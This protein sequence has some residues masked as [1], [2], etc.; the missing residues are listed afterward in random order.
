[1]APT[2]PGQAP[3][4]PPE[5][6]ARRVR[7]AIGAWFIKSP[8][9]GYLLAACRIEVDPEL[10]APAATDGYNLLVV[11]P[12]YLEPFI[13]RGS[14]ALS[15][16]LA[17]E[18]LHIAL[19]HA[20][21][22]GSRDPRLWNVAADVV[23]NHIVGEADP[24]AMAAAEAAVN[25]LG[26]EM[27][28]A[29]RVAQALV[30]QNPLYRGR[31]PRDVEEELTRSSAE[32]I[33]GAL[34]NAAA[35]SLPKSISVPQLL[36]R[37]EGGGGA[38]GRRG[39]PGRTPP[40]GEGVEDAARSVAGR[41]TQGGR[42]EPG[43]EGDLPRA[44][45]ARGAEGEQGEGYWKR[46]MRE[47]A[48]YAK[49]AGHKLP[50]WAEILL[51]RARARVGWRS[52][53]RTALVTALSRRSSST[54]RVLHRKFPGILPGE[55][56]VGVRAIWCLV[57]TSGS[58][59]GASLNQVVAEVL[60]ISSMFG[61]AAR[62]VAWESG[63]AEEVDI[64]TLRR[65]MRLHGGGGTDLEPALT[66]LARKF[67]RGDALVI[68]T[69]GEIYDIEEPRVQQLLQDHV[70]RSSAAIFL[71]TLKVPAQLPRRLRVVKIDV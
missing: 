19:G 70:S 43:G 30:S 54:F 69:D 49:A 18:V 12:K 42:T 2:A 48:A 27:V 62:M 4:R 7:D 63:R 57:D 11:N 9:L 31:D 55:V 51:E 6:Y 13:Q 53:L 68:L 60:S 46:V 23:V 52:L 56:R 32:E 33:Y 1:V 5:W 25:D 22:R 8:F 40:G 20:A 41:E 58:M 14:D 28:T 24:H 64:R 21:R 71:T 16:L 34:E 61:Y 26:G 35:A 3:A 38:P 10:D 47:A 37:G 65:L 36:P 66:Y 44:G 17:H 59:V 50:G 29:S 67:R 45:E 15:F 39:Q